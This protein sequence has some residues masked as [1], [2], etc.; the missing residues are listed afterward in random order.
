MD[1]VGH[2]AR[3]ILI[4]RAV[5]VGFQLISERSSWLLLRSMIES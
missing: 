5:R 4:Q 1:V 3:R 2:V